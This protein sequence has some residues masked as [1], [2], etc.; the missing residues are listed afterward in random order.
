MSDSIIDLLDQLPS[1]NL[2]VKTLNALDF[3]VPG[4]WENVVG[5]DKTIEVITGETDADRIMDIRNKAI[6][7]YNDADNGYQGAIWY[8]NLVDNLDGALAAAAMA[9][10]VSEKIPF[11]SFLGG[12]TPKADTTQSID[13]CLKI[14][15]EL[16]AYSKL[17]G[18]PILNPGEFV[19]NLTEEY[20]GPSLMRM[21]ALVC[22]DG[23]IPLGPDFLQKVQDTLDGEGESAFADNAVFGAIS[24]TIPGDDKFGFISETF[25]AVQ[26]WMDNLVGSVGL[27]PE[28]I[29]DKIGGFI[30]F[31]DDA[32]DVVAAFLDKTTN[33]F[34]HTGTQSV[35]RKL[36][37][38]AAEEA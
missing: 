35:A 4:E 7:L 21:A 28:S 32:L 14:V 22:L 24:D 38:R 8:Y 29:F 34:Q 31:S 30:D 10:I 2:T 33:Y 13:L 23:L 26:G 19:T 27:T 20:S 18:L 36:I 12:L 17:N 15:A 6:E 3:V 25:G 37:Q 9:E 16:I 5:F 1:N 11:L